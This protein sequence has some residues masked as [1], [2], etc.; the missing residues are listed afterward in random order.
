MSKLP[1][2]PRPLLQCEIIVVIGFMAGVKSLNKMIILVFLLCVFGLATFFL[3]AYFIIAYYFSR[4]PDVYF[5]FSSI[6]LFGLTA[7]FA[8]FLGVSG[9]FPN[10]GKRK[11][12]AAGLALIFAIPFCFIVVFGYSFSENF[13][14]TSVLLFFYFCPLI[15]AALLCGVEKQVA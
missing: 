2:L 5:L 4:Q 8:Y 12:F 3:Y 10:L 6:I 9:L 7:I 14:F 13:G 15:A 11:P 1:K